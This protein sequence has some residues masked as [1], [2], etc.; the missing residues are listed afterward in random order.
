MDGQTLSVYVSLFL[1]SEYIPFQRH[2]LGISY[3][4]LRSFVGFRTYGYFNF[5]II[6]TRLHY[7]IP[8]L[9]YRFI[10][11]DWYILYWMCA[12]QSLPRYII[13]MT[14]NDVSY[15]TFAVGMVTLGKN[16]LDDQ[17]YFFIFKQ[18]CI[19]RSLFHLGS[20]NVN[21]SKAESSTNAVPPCTCHIRK[22]W[23]HDGNRF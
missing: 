13:E 9:S 15:V 2:R 16:I 12:R 22:V 3:K 6:S 21:L 10:C 14:C 7:D 19:C 4:I 18:Y 20:N 8:Q 1:S 17:W 23:P 11:L 5:N